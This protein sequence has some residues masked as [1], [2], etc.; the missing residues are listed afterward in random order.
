[1]NT[2]I[3]SKN[4]A[5]YSRGSKIGY[6]EAYNRAN[7]TFS[8]GNNDA[9]LVD[10]T[11]K[12]EAKEVFTKDNNIG[13]DNN[14]GTN[15]NNEAEKLMNV[16]D[17][18]DA[19]VNS[20][21]EPTALMKD[22][23]DKTY[24]KSLITDAFYGQITDQNDS[25]L[26]NALLNASYSHHM[27]YYYGNN[28]NGADIKILLKGGGA[29]RFYNNLFL[30]GLDATRANK[31][32]QD[33][34]EKISDI[35]VDLYIKGI[36][37]ADGSIA[38]ILILLDLIKA[39]GDKIMEMVTSKKTPIEQELTNQVKALMKGCDFTSRDDPNKYEGCN[40]LFNIL[41]ITR[42]YYGAIKTDDIKVELELID[43]D[44]LKNTIIQNTDY[45]MYVKKS[46]MIVEGNDKITNLY[47]N[48][49]KKLFIKY[50]NMYRNC[51]SGGM[52]FGLSRLCFNYNVKFTFP[53]NRQNGETTGE[54]IVKTFKSPIELYDLGINIKY[55]NA[56]LYHKNM[57]IGKPNI[58][59]YGHVY[60]YALD[61]VVQDLYNMIFGEKVLPWSAK[62]Y[63]KRLKRFYYY[64]LLLE[65]DNNN[66][67]DIKTNI[68]YIT[69]HVIGI[70][71]TPPLPVVPNV[72]TIKTIRKYITNIQM[73]SYKFQKDYSYLYYITIPLITF[74]ITLMHITYIVYS[75]NQ[76]DANKSNI[77]PRFLNRT[78]NDI[79]YDFN[80]DES[81]LIQEDLKLNAS[82]E[83]C[84]NMKANIINVSSLI[85]PMEYIQGSNDYYT[86]LLTGFDK[87][88]T[89]ITNQLAV[90]TAILDNL[91]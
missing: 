41:G 26:Y 43:T 82:M 73:V 87:F 59:R 69:E 55:T 85:K 52:E 18:D 25:Y 28:N 9:V 40:K 42:N 27:Q 12:F 44:D 46:R 10:D 66:I 21:Y 30:K 79:L 81:Y 57:T 76:D 50:A 83:S 45:G 86:K 37:Y 60:V 39:D 58:N 32:Q 65:L 11:A 54:T 2:Y 31:I 84:K 78:N 48:L 13:T 35:D 89:D 70:M 24:V 38:S 72:D 51:A 53:L 5:L 22:F 75:K 8:T 80:K 88:M 19:N 34:K 1:M 7:T 3:K 33:Y 67:E 62:K 14:N 15:N 77:I 91:E 61:Y 23:D 71:Q 68:K 6:N 90:I 64:I 17:F 20:N 16:V 29:C 4:G 56:Y 36:S 63:E 74:L 47:N 49:N